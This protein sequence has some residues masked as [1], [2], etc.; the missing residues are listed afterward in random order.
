LLAAALA[1]V[2]WLARREGRFRPQL[3]LAALAILAIDLAAAQQYLFVYAPRE[4]WTFQTRFS[5]RL[6]SSPQRVYRTQGLLPPSFKTAL[7]QNRYAEAIEFDRQTLSP[8]Y[9]LPD[10]QRVLPVSQSVAGHD[11]D[12]VLDAGTRYTRRHAVGQLPDALFDMWAVETAIVG[13]QSK[14]LFA[15]PLEIAEAAYLGQRPTAFPRAWIVHQVDVH[16]RFQSRSSRETLNFTYRLLYP[17]NTPRDWRR[18]AVVETEEAV[19]L[20]AGEATEAP[21]G[22]SCTIERDDPLT[23]EVQATLTAPGLVVLADQFCPGWELTVETNGQSR[24]LPIL[25]TN[26]VLRGAV[27]PTG[28]HRL[29]YRYRPKSFFA[30]AI[31]SALACAG[32]GIAVAVRWRQTR[33]AK[34]P[35]KGN[36][37]AMAD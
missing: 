19:N 9:P 11:F 25:R 2:F 33:T 24:T 5:E 36:A 17:N 18:V 22:E 13:T 29:I 21:P 23:V 7:S 4:L 1:L 8:K 10:R 28:E 30:G 35:T 37:K 34:G 6:G 32:V 15:S 14:G 27:L 20:P 31:I 26:R 3:Q 16:D 12:M